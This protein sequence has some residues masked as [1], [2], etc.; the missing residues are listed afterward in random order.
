MA[1]TAAPGF[2]GRTRERDALDRLLGEVRGGHGA[3][4]VFRGE[5]GAGKTALLRYA[6]RRAS[7]F[8]VAEI[9]GVEAE[10]EL[11]FAAV[12]Q[13][14]TPL[15]A[16]L[17]ALDGSQRDALRIALG[18]SSGAP[19]TRASPP[20]RRSRRPTGRSVSAP[21]RVRS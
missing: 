16:R 18:L 17:D 10:M 7:G 1:A 2:L 21:V 15:L 13:L 6:A 8:R 14:C 20:P 5:A 12:H 9:A 11:A 19:P 3:V 4:L